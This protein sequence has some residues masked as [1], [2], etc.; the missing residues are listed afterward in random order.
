MKRDPDLARSQLFLDD[1]WVEDV[2]R[3]T[4]LWHKADIYPEPLVRPDQ[5]WETRGL[6]LYGTVLRL[7]RHVADVLLRRAG[8]ALLGGK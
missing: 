8:P 2:Q 1:N 4:R 7:G 5:P 3:L 6:V